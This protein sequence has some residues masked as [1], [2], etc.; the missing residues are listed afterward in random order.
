MRLQLKVGLPNES[1]ALKSHVPVSHAAY[2]ILK[3]T[4]EFAGRASHDDGVDQFDAVVLLQHCL[5]HCNW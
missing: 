1:C 4:R 5:V 2:G 3:G